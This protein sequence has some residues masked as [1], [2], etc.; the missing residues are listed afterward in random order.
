MKKVL[1][2]SDL[3]GTLLNPESKISDT[4]ARLL[5][6]AI[7]Q[8][9]LFT[10]ATARTP[11]TVSGILRDVKMSLPAIVMTG[12]ALWHQDSNTYS[13]VKFMDIEVANALMEIYR[14]HGLPTFV[15]TLGNDSIID[16]YHPGPLSAVER[17]FIDER[18]DNPYKRFHEGTL[19]TRLD[20]VLLFYGLEP[21][22]KAREVYAD[23]VASGIACNPL[24]YFDIF[25]QDVGIL[26]MF[27]KP[28]TKAAAVSAM[29]QHLGAESIVVFGDNVNDLSMMSIADIAVAPANAI[30]EVKRNANM[31]IGPN[32]DDAV[33]RFIT[34]HLND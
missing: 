27:P 34:D 17:Q 16:I 8:G 22:Q 5:N 1:Y 24:C 30:D 14:R 6:A 18:I 23:V 29:A 32:S 21:P 3:D 11:A 33:A 13:E 12:G 19:P 7:A 15:Y 10:I 20:R 9:A 25:G 26:E 2:V 28:T 31:V 4:S